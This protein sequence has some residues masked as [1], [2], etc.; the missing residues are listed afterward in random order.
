MQLTQRIITPDP[1]DQNLIVS[2][3]HE[4]KP[5]GKASKEK[6]VSMEKSVEYVKI[7]EPGRFRELW[8]GAATEL[9][10]VRFP[11]Q[12]QQFLDGETQVADGTPLASITCLTGEE[13]SRLKGQKIQTAEQLA[14]ASEVTIKALGMGGRD[15]CNKVAKWLAVAGGEAKT[16]Q[17]I[18]DSTKG[19]QEQID[20]LTNSLEQKDTIIASMKEEKKKEKLT[21]GKKDDSSNNSTGSD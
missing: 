11:V 20:K 15:L 10:K 8:S 1:Q 21:L 4:M 3:R 6:G 16:M 12:Y 14:N 13:K 18:E 7:S 17:M 5:D 19:M 9:H 2:F